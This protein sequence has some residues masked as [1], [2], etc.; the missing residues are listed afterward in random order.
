M[1]IPAHVDIG[2]NDRADKAAEEALEQ[3]VATGHKVSKLDYCRWV[4]EE[5][6]RKCQNDWSNSGNTMMATKP[7]VNRYSNTE[8]MPHRHQV[9]I[10]R[11]RMGYTN[12]MHGYRINDEIRPL[13]IDCNQ[14]ITAE[15]QI[16]RHR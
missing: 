14:D 4:K 6:K 16:Y 5:F 10:S 15:H 8:G 11:L 12:L 3:E 9:I 13:C 2:G 1:W 7:D